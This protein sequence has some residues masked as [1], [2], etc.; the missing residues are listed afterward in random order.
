MTTIQIPAAT[1]ELAEGEIYAGI[2]F[3]EAPYHLI[4][5]PG[6]QDGAPLQVQLDWA[7]SIGGDLPTRRELGLLRVNAREQFRDDWYWSGEMYKPG[8]SYA[9]YQTFSY[10]RQDYTSTDDELR[11]RAVRR[12]AV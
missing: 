4:L 6:D 1:L 10:G 3:G 8:S 5:L 11:A 2:I 12:S 7:K 9:W